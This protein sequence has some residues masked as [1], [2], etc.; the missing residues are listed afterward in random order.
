M[1]T[2]NAQN[3][4]CLRRIVRFGDTDGAGVIHFYQLLRW[5]HEAW[6]ESLEV[7]GIKSID[8]FPSIPDNV[9]CLNFALPIVHCEADFLS[10]VCVGDNLVVK[11]FP[12][13]K[14]LT[15]FQVQYQFQRDN[16]TVAYGLIAH[17]AIQFKTR[18]PCNLPEGIERWLEASSLNKG[19][20]S[21]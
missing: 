13:K 20:K 12:I 16:K 18:Q 7:Y 1:P 4:L 5:C 2:T 10:P 3:W 19:I 6:E 8:I 9:S 15:S 21:L 11:L 14:G 17:C